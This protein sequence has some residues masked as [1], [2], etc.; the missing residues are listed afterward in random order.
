[1]NT[2]ANASTRPPANHSRL[3]GALITLVII[4]IIALIAYYFSVRYE[5]YEETVYI[6]Y[7]AEARSN[8]F[9]AAEKFLSQQ[10]IEVNVSTQLQSLDELQDDGV[11]VIFDAN[12]VLNQRSAG[13]LL[14][15]MKQGGRVV[16][17]AALSSD[18]S[19]QD[20]L[21]S[22][23]NVTKYVADDGYLEATGEL[24]LDESGFI[25]EDEDLDGDEASGAKPAS[26]ESVD[27]E[28]ADEKVG[29]FDE[30]KKNMERGLLS[31]QQRRRMDDLDQE[32]AR[33]NWEIDKKIRKR[34]AWAI[35]ENLLS[36]KFE[37]DDHPL[38]VDLS[39]SG[40]LSHPSLYDEYEEEYEYE[41]D[42]EGDDFSEYDQLEDYDFNDESEAWQAYENRQVEEEQGGYEY[43]PF[44]WVGNDS[45]VGLMQFEVG[46]GLLTVMADVNVFTS[47]QIGL[48]DH[49]MLLK[50]LSSGTS[51]VTFLYGADVPHLIELM[52]L[53]YFEAFVAALLLLVVWIFYRVRRFGPIKTDVDE[54]RR[55]F[56]EHMS[57]TGQYLW[58]NNLNS[59]LIA[60]VRQEIWP[61]MRK[62]HPGFD[63]LSESSKL[64]ALAAAVKI[65]IEEAR[66]L[67]MSEA[68]N[69]EVHFFQQIKLLQKLRKQL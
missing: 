16:V 34:E 2:S 59:D 29:E 44:Y 36:V 3:K 64:E 50:T 33:N 58:R 46:G 30:F 41:S 69:D 61:L 47:P 26:E 54:H 12:S 65:E 48:F 31:E 66:Q 18:D 53:H 56:Q 43:E 57:A 67:M 23:F 62:R 39:G 6:G 11:L 22:Q 7:S 49:G 63:S 25:S 20:I 15:W 37:G 52:W 35:H 51:K 4:A 19:E 55:S 21:L 1:M 32:A 38:Y 40:S 10:D 17:A 28:A 8:P 13:R 14:E 60:S 45:A 27:E 5:R 68:S 24:D 9:L 42:Y